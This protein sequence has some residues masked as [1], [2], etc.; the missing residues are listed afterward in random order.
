MSLLPL[1]S[2]YKDSKDKLA[3][4]EVEGKVEASQPMV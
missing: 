4:G 2:S 1:C 3:S